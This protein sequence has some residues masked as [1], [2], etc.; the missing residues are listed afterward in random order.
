LE[1][2]MLLHFMT[3]CD[4]YYTAIWYN[5]WPFGIVCGQFAY[6]LGFGMFGPRKIWQPCCLF[7]QKCF[8]LVFEPRFLLGALTQMKTFFL[9]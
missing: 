5:L 3:I 2:K 8:A 4:T 1:W 7:N 9:I 6:L